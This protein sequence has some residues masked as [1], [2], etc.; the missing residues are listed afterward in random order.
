MH[1]RFCVPLSNQLSAHNPNAIRLQSQGAKHCFW[2]GAS[3]VEDM[4]VQVICPPACPVRL[5]VHHSTK[6][7]RAIPPRLQ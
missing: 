3:A 6:L 5:A 2:H 4:R 1:S 7:E